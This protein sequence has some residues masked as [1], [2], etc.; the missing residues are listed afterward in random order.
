MTFP[1]LCVIKQAS[2]IIG[3]LMKV[4][5]HLSSSDVTEDQVAL[6]RDAKS[7]AL[8]VIGGLLAVAALLVVFFT[9]S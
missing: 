8:M 5:Q 9:F 6:A 4:N 1:V 7:A 3:D 2:S